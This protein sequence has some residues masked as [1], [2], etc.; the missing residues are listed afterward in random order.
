MRFGTSIVGKQFEWDAVTGDGSTTEIITARAAAAISFED[1]LRYTTG[2]H[3]Q[4]IQTANSARAMRESLTGM[5][6]TDDDYPVKFNELIEQRLSFEKAT[7][8]ASV[9]I[10]LILVNESDRAKLRPSL[11]AGDPRQVTELRS[12]LEREVLAS[13]EED[14]VV[15]T[16]VDPTLPQSP[17][18]SVSNPDS[19]DGSAS[20]ES[21]STD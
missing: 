8:A 13:N 6:P 19:G 14:A 7:W 5:S 12:W 15:A 11:V 21:S 10:L 4:L 2:R 20:E 3:A 18:P 1:T 16:N 9:D 17:P